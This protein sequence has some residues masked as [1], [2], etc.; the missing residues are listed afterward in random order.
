MVHFMLNP[1]WRIIVYGGS[2]NSCPT[3]SRQR[4]L[5]HAL[6]CI[7]DQSA[8]SPKSGAQAKQIVLQAVSALEDCL[9]FNA[10]RGS[11]PTK[12]GDHEVEQPS[13][14]LEPSAKECDTSLKLVSLMASPATL[15]AARGRPIR[16]AGSL[17]KPVQ[18]G[19]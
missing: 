12:S 14:A 18:T 10:G 17:L 9:L 13:L 2:G 1:K 4:D 7:V 15:S 3:V 8:E 19:R 5:E 11:A 6:S 16:T